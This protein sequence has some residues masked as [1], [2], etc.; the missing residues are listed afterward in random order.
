ME[1]LRNKFKKERIPLI[2]NS[3][4]A[5]MRERFSSPNGGRKH[6]AKSEDSESSLKKVRA[7]SH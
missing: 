5:K 7:V 4:V 1:S 3:E 2:G 6:R